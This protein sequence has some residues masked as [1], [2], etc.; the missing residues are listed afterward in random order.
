MN[1][2]SVCLVAGIASLVGGLVTF[3]YAGPE[4]SWLGW[5]LTLFGAAASVLGLVPDQLITIFKIPGTAAEDLHHARSSSPST[6]SA[7]TS[8]CR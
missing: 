7:T 8:R 1:W 5:T 6:A 3:S 2:R 4:L